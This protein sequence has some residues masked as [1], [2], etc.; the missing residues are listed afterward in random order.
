MI[1]GIYPIISGSKNILNYHNESNFKSNN[2]IF[3]ARVGSAGDIL[4]YTGDVYLTDLA[5]AIITNININN[6]YLYLY[7]LNHNNKIKELCAHNAAPNINTTILL[8]KL[9][10][11]IPSLEDQEKIVSMIDEINNEENNFHKNIQSIKENIK[12]I[13]E[14]VEYIVDKTNYN[15]DNNYDNNDEDNNDDNDNN[16]LE[17]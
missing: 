6:E 17:D 14:C 13:Y 4:K 10:I 15:N 7:L 16:E 5:F 12:R 9:L 11:P 1:N 3:M 2:T 8:N